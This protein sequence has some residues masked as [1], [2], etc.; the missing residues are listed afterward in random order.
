MSTATRVMHMQR[1][2]AALEGWNFSF[3]KES[4]GL[5]LLIGMVLISAFLVVYVKDLDRR[6]FSQVQ[7]EQQVRNKLQVEWGQLLLEQ[8]TLATQAR[9]QTIARDQLNMHSPDAART[10]VVT[11]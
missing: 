3:S 7:T 6:L 4:L 9:V 8:S 11:R 10:E 1:N 2:Q 5:L